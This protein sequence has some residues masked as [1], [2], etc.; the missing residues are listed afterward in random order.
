MSGRGTYTVY[1][2]FR[3]HDMAACEQAMLFH[4]NDAAKAGVLQCVESDGMAWL[5][6][7]HTTSANSPSGIHLVN[8][9]LP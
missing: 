9:T 5:V 4:R 1:F 6:M 3:Q 7:P 8:V 2:M